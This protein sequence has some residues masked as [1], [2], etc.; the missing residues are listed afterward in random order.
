[1]LEP[2]RLVLGSLGL[3][4]LLLKAFPRFLSS[5][6]QAVVTGAEAFFLLARR[7]LR[8]GRLSVPPFRLR[9][10]FSA[11]RFF[12]DDV[13]WG[14]LLPTLPAHL[15]AVEAT[16]FAE[17]LIGLLKPRSRLD[18]LGVGLSSLPLRLFEARLEIA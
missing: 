16:E 11:A 13:A 12:F 10:R 15:G 7:F 2:E 3:A 9:P 8:G 14:Q 5:F 4:F 6:F 1:L 18:R 17:A